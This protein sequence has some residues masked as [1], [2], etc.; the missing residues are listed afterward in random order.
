VFRSTSIYFRNTHK[1][2]NKDKE[3][4]EENEEKEDKE[5]DL[6]KVYCDEMRFLSTFPLRSSNKK[7]D[8]RNLMY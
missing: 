8:Y 7:I 4:N 2:D 1:E 3:K 6:G 5:D